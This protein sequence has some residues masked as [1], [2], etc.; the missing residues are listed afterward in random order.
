MLQRMLKVC[1]KNEASNKIVR[2]NIERHSLHN[3]RFDK[4][5]EAEAT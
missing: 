1:W 3:N 4:A 5:E 2:E